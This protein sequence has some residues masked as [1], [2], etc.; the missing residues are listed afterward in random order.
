MYALQASLGPASPFSRDRW[1]LDASAA[2]LKQKASSGRNDMSQRPIL[3]TILD[4][5]THRQNVHVSF[6]C[7]MRLAPRREA[8]SS[9]RNLCLKLIR[10]FQDCSY[11]GCCIHG[12]R[13]RACLSASLQ[14]LENKPNLYV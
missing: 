8:V 9:N 6:N 12:L 11:L 7:G 3:S 5:R 14:L 10:L 2:S 1:R 4:E 13:H